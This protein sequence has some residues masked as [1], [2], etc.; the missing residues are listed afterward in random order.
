MTRYIEELVFFYVQLFLFAEG[1][2]Q[3][4]LSDLEIR[5]IILY[6]DIFQDIFMEIHDRDYIRRCPK[7]TSSFILVF[8]DSFPCGVLLYLMPHFFYRAFLDERDHI[9]SR[10][11]ILRSDESGDIFCSH[12]LIL[13]VSGHLQEYVV[14]IYDLPGSIELQYHIGLIQCLGIF[15]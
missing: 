11:I 9:V 10:D 3:F 15:F 5:D 2:F 8:Y 6:D 12:E 4:L 13:L 1:E 14:R 7:K